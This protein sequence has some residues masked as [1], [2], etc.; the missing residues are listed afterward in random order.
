MKTLYISSTERDMAGE[1]ELLHRQVIP[2]IRQ[3]ALD[4]GE[5]VDLCDLRH[6]Q[7]GAQEQTQEQLLSVCLDEIDRCSPHMIVL[8]GEDYGPF[9]EESLRRNLEP[10]KPGL[11]LESPD[12]SLTALEVQYGALEKKD[13][14]DKIL[15]YFRQIEGEI[16]EFCQPESP[17]HQQAL[18][19]LKENIRAW[20]GDRVKTYTVRW[21]EES[22]GFSGLDAFAAMVEE[23]LKALDHYPLIEKSAVAQYMDEAL[24]LLDVS[25]A[26]LVH[27]D[28]DTSHIFH[29]N[30]HFTGFIDF[31][32]IRGCH[33]FFDLGTLLWADDTPDR[34]QY[35]LV[36]EGYSQ[37]TPLSTK[38]HQRIAL[39]GLYQLLRFLNR[40]K[41]TPMK[42]FWNQK[43]LRHLEW[44]R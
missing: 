27:G 13:R 9:L 32:E 24:S 11:K 1:R 18:D 40:K 38:D 21:D 3:L 28:F 20:A 16:P 14:Q 29:E 33:P 23:D 15:F 7:S 12:L 4:Y 22:G 19:A 31:G 5:A 37:I 44:M 43:T 25:Q 35:R 42:E 41:D 10:Q 2:T 8:M 26:C 36:C 34:I 6:N 39:I 30:G 17:R